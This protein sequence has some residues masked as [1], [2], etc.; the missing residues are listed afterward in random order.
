MSLKNRVIN[1]I[2]LRIGYPRVRGMMDKQKSV[3]DISNALTSTSN[4]PTRFEIPLE[5]MKLMKEREDFEMKQTFPLRRMLSIMRNIHK[6][7]DSLSDNP[8]TPTNGTSGDFIDELKEFAYSQG[9]D[10][11]H[12]ANL[13][14]D[15]VFQEFGVLFDNAIVLAMEMSQE[16]IYQAPSQA[17]FKMVFD[18]YDTLGIA[19]NRIAAFLREQGYAAQADHPLGGTVLYPPLAQKAGIGWVGK[20]GL[21]ITP[22][23]G[24][25]IRLAAV[26][27]SI[28]NLPDSK[29]NN[30]SW[31]QEYCEICGRCIKEC[32]PQAIMKETV[33]KDT[34][35]KTD[36]VQWD[37]FEY[38]LVNYGCSVCVK[39]CPFSKGPDA[40][41][42]LRQVVEKR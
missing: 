10:I 28:Q 6:T 31:I 16:K 12:F 39:V 21:L 4:S 40:Y 26:Y 24:S 41:A 1:A 36:I 42:S 35:L 33:V 37:C 15:L 3:S 20:H 2:L 32:P 19:A 14:S 30:H 27:T 25:R 5:A 38:F 17:T 18:T 9:V 34:G 29:E 8:V 11:I 22:K 23:F 13:P 7:V